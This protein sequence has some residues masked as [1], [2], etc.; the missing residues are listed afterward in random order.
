[1][2]SSSYAAG[3]LG[4]HEVCLRQF[5]RKLRALAPVAREQRAPPAGWS[6]GA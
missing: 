4:T 6:R 3:P 1:M 5:A 2:A